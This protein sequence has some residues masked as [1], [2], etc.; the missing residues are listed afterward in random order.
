MVS[1][2][3]FLGVP[4]VVACSRR[5]SPGY[6]GYAFVANHEGRAV[7]AVDLQA[8]VVAR[9]IPIEGAPTQILAAR[10]RPAVYALAPEEGLLLE[11]SLDR[12]SVR[13]KLNLGPAIAMSV[14]AT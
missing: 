1:R 10:T 6:R 13:R 8:M 3:T 9:H 11:I 12:L 5:G 2:R 7:A 14:D 4:L